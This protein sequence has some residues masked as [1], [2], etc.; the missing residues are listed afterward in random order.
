MRVDTSPMGKLIEA[1]R[2]VAFSAHPYGHPTIG[3]DSDIIHTTI[4]DVEKFHKKFYVPQ[5]IT[6]A[7]VGDVDLDEIKKMANIYFGE[8]KKKT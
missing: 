6:I 7:I 8:I 2:S 3:W 5:N 1:F 4:K